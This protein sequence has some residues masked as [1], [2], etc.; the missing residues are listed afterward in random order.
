[1]AQKVQVLL[2]DDIDGGEATETVSFGLDGVA[3]EIDL[4]TGNADQLRSA[5][6]AYVE[7]G[8]KS[9]GGSI[10][11]GGA[12]GRR[13]RNGAGREH[14]ARIREWARE[15]G[16]KVNERGRIPADIVA[17]YEAAH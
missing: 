6:A 12:V 8:R 10:R 16:E 4:S 7:S 5:L 1:M 11:R 9:V 2:I 15:Q 13:P 14:S 3:Y 17:K